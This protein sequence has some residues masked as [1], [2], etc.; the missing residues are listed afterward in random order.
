MLNRREALGAMLSVPLVGMVEP[1]TVKVLS[2]DLASEPHRL[3]EV[4]WFRWSI[5]EGKETLTVC[6]RTPGGDWATETV[7]GGKFWLHQFVRLEVSP[8]LV[9]LCVEDGVL[10]DV[11]IGCW[12]YFMDDQFGWDDFRH[13]A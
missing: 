5:I 7:E 9:K 2:F 6:H 4:D 12:T 1:Q 11:R 3:F 8:G 10:T 13:T